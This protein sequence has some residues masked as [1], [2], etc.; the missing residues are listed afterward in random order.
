VSGGTTFS[1]C[2]GGHETA[3]RTSLLPVCQVFASFP[4]GFD[5]NFHV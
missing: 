2:L 1:L 5:A 3:V 4:G